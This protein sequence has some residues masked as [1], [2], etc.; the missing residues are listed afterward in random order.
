MKTVTLECGHE[1]GWAE[2][3]GPGQ[4]DFPWVGR[5]AF[6]PACL[7]EHEIV[8]IDP[9]HYNVSGEMLLICHEERRKVVWDLDTV[10][11]NPQTMIEYL[12]YAAKGE[13]AAYGETVFATSKGLRLA[14]EALERDTPKLTK[15]ASCGV[16]M[17]PYEYRRGDPQPSF[18]P[19][20]DMNESLGERDSVR[21][22]PECGADWDAEF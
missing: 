19:D 22:C 4:E 7:E 14:R 16:L 3:G 21:L 18:L 5:F 11:E 13:Y 10:F 15:C 17:E 9:T 12:E 2:W 1:V 20:T 8:E 6:C